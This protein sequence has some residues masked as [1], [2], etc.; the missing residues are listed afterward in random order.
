MYLC[1]AATKEGSNRDAVALIEESKQG[2]KEGGREG[3]R[4]TW[5]H[6]TNDLGHRQHKDVLSGGFLATDARGIA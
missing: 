6:E 1:P 4:L 3:G 5:L 2:K